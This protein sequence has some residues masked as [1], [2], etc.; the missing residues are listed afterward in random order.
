M[1]EEIQ[2]YKC[3]NCAA[4]LRFNPQKQGFVCEY[5]DSFFTPEECKKANEQMASQK[6]EQKPHHDEF[7]EG[8]QLYSCPSCGAELVTDLNTSATECFFCHNPVVLKGRLSGEYRP[9]RVI[10]FKLSR[11]DA[12]RL[13]KEWCGKRKFLPNDF[14]S[15]SQLLHMAG[16]YVPF[17]VANCDVKGRMQ[18]VC[19]QVRSWTSGEYRYTEVKEYDVLRDASLTFE[20]IPA[21]GASKIE[22]D[23][24]EAI[25]PFNYEAAQPFE[26]SYLSGF[27]S[28]KY[29]VNK[30]QVFPRIR[31]RAVNGSDALLRSSMIGYDSVRVIQSDMQV[32]K[33]DWEYMLLPVWFMTYQY[34]GKQYSFAINGQTG[35][36]AGTPPLAKNKLMRVCVLVF[37][38]C[39]AVGILVGNIMS[40]F[41]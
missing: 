13:F 14:T 21:D 17:W 23:L 15:Q 7:E 18:A 8:N 20:G 24:M 5:C 31:N 33:T 11:D 29:D 25:E 2:Q 12:N 1:S 26:M 40:N 39:L 30:S 22:D 16:V 6:E 37:A 19:K 35:K 3:P 32:L 27:L 38:V 41:M 4:E 34:E 9:A 28:D 10:P 36:Q